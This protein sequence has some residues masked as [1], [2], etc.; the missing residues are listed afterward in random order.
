MLGFT[1]GGSL[2]TMCFALLNQSYREGIKGRPFED[3]CQANFL[4]KSTGK[5]LLD[6]FLLS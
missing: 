5:M 2:I 1:H 6:I 4:A 3:T